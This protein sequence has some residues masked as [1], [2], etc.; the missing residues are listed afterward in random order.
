MD[1]IAYNA[2]VSYARE[3]GDGPSITEANRAMKKSGLFPKDLDVAKAR[4]TVRSMK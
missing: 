1:A 3:T 4:K 2:A